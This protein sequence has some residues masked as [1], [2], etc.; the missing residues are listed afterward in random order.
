MKNVANVDEYIASYPAEVRAVL[1]R[2]RETIRAAVPEAGEKISYQI[3]TVTLEGKY[4]VY[5]AAWKHHLA[6]YPVPEA[7]GEL[8]REMAPYRAAK[9]TLRFPY[10]KPIPYDL[11]GRVVSRLKESGTRASTQTA[12]GTSSNR[13]VRRST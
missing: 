6:V 5:Y 7:E 4:L 12:G 2:V 13:R 9:G 10:A 11:I 1:E 3:P 8:E